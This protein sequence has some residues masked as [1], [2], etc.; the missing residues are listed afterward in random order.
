MDSMGMADAIPRLGAL[1]HLGLA[2]R[3]QGEKGAAGVHLAERRFL[4]K[5]NLRG[6]SSD[7]GFMSGVASALG[8]VEPP[9]VPNTAARAGRFDL[10]WLGPDE[11]LVVAADG[12]E[13]ELEARLNAAIGAHGG[14]VTDVSETRTTIVVSGPSARDMLAKGCP[15]DLHPRAF[16]GGACAQS[17]VA[18][19][20]VILHRTDAGAAGEP[21]RFELHVLRS[22][23]DYLWRFLEDAGQEYGVAVVEK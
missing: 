18:K 4:A 5:L 20:G 7:R 16:A 1:D 9:I 11:W 13:A 22:F 21:A 15:L 2:A 10:L 23:A 6:D 17:L 3:A 8:G 19:V 14:T 12:T